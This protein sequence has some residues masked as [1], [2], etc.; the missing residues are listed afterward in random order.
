MI[1]PPAH[2]PEPD[3]IPAAGATILPRS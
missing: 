2:D 1:P 3:T